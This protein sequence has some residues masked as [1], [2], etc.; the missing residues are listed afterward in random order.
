MVMG[1]LDSH[2]QKNDT[3]LV[4]CIIYINQLGMDE[5][6]EYKNW[7]HE[8][9]QENRVCKLLDIGLHNVLHLTPKVKAIK[10]KI[11]K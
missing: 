1:K 11:S 2:M 6:L 4:S 5:I 9:I 7:N 3:E 10:A 8:L